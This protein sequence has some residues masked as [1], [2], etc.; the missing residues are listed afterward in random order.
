MNQRPHF[1]SLEVW[2]LAHALT[3]EIYRL[4]RTFPPEERYRL[5]DQLC[6]A[7]AS[8]PANIAEGEGREQSKDKIHFLHMARGSLSEARY[9]TRLSRDLGYLSL[10][11]ETVVNDLA[12]K[13]H[14]K[15]HAYIQSKNRFS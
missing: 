4:T 8:I 3:L 6:R 13:L 2:Q 5:V 12:S 1:E 11:Q 10:E 7:A 9:F 14:A 15:L